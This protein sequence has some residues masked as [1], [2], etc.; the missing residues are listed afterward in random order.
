MLKTSHILTIVVLLGIAHAEQYKISVAIREPLQK[1]EFK[2]L[3]T[4]EVGI[5]M[6]KL[7]LSL[8]NVD[9]TIYQ[10]CLKVPKL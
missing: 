7:E 2:N 6:G 1:P 5:R 8:E 4:L 3:A 9:S 10:E